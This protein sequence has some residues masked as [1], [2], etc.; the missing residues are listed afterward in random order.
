MKTMLTLAFALVL[1]SSVTIATIGCTKPTTEKKVET[2]T[3]TPEGTT[4]TEAKTT[5]TKAEE[6]KAEEPKK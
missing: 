2:M 6:P 4:T 1:G 5:E 3:K